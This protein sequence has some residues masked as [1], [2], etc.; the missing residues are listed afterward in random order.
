MPVDREYLTRAELAE[1]LT[2]R[3]FP[4][5]RSTLNKLSMPSRGEGPPPAGFWSNKALYEPT[6]ALDW[7]KSRFRKNWRGTST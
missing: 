1:F 6:K 3:G 5:S 7:A 4:I 2:A